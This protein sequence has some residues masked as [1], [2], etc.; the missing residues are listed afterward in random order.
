MGTSYNSLGRQRD[1]EISVLAEDEAKVREREIDQY[2]A[3]EKREHQGERL[4][5]TIFNL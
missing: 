5:Y 4:N 1:S 3:M 2:F